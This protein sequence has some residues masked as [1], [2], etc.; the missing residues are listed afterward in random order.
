MN[1]KKIILIALSKAGIDWNKIEYLK[2]DLLSIWFNIDNQK[3]VLQVFEDTENN[4]DNEDNENNENHITYKLFKKEENKG[5][6]IFTGFLI[7]E[8]GK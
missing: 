4:E 3:Y 1:K 7:E 8:I 2:E 5:T 6:E